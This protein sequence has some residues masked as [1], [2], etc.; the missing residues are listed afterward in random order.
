MTTRLTV[1]TNMT[2]NDLPIWFCQ[3]ICS[4]KNEMSTGSPNENAVGCMT[5]A[6]DV[7]SPHILVEKM[8]CKQSKV[9][10]YYLKDHASAAVCV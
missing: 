10:I 3:S 6:S 2:S 9:S 4:L 1:A 5:R 7:V 8:P